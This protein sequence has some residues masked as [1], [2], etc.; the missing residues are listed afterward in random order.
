MSEEKNKHSA[1]RVVAIVFTAVV[2]LAGISLLPFEKWTKGKINDF[3]L[4]GDI[5][6]SSDSVSDSIDV[7]DGIGL[8]G[9]EDIDPEL[10]IAMSESSHQK[11]SANGSENKVTAEEED[12]P[13]IAKEVQ[14]SKQG[15]QMVLEDYTASGQGLKRLRHSLAAGGVT[16]I[17]VIGD[18]YI[19][20]DIFT[21]DLRQML[22]SEYGGSGVG[23]VNMHSDFPGFRRSVK[24]GGKGW[25]EFSA[26]KKADKRYTGLS[27]HYFVSTDNSTAT[28]KG[29]GTLPHL[30]TWD[31][32][33]FLFISPQN[34]VIKVKTGNGG[35]ESHNI[36]G[37][38]DVQC[39]SVPGTT[40][41]FEISTSTPGIIGLG[42]WMY[43]N[44][45]VTLDC[46][47][48]RGF[49]GLTLNKVSPEL[50]RQMAR[51]IDYDLII[52][53]FGINAM[54]PKQT[55]FSVYSNRMVNVISHIRACYPQAD[56]I[57]MGIGDRG[58]KK[59]GEV[60]SMSSAP[61]MVKAQRDAARK[62]GCLFYDTRESMGGND[63]IVEWV[64]Q[65]LANKDYIHLTH[66]GGK[67]L[68]EP[69]FNAIKTNVAR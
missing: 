53:E 14:P 5:V 65:G 44:K 59:G 38:P 35:W 17:A 62:A 34:S 57:M 9:A 67:K 29:T 56:I 41:N 46:M 8:A 31:N 12:V 19:E 43:G 1:W 30:A 60:H 20:G 39:I 18:S 6:D 16:R 23:F 24:Q 48:S 68:A 10:Q 27:Q 64:R 37:S 50:S 32:S 36:T 63:A 3:N 47:S 49:S 25:T 42:T 55:D 21:Q 69:L 66:K 22:Q 2:L 61:Y 52:L 58:E 4:I 33:K 26:N 13:A 51:Y 7:D 28:Y 15:S 11:D 40:G 45:G 54:S